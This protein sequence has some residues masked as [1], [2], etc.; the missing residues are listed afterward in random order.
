[1]FMNYMKPQNTSADSS[2]VNSS[3]LSPDKTPLHAAVYSCNRTSI[4]IYVECV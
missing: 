2:T 1:M 4:R 3:E